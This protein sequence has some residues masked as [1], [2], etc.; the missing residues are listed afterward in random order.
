MVDGGYGHGVITH[1]HPT[2][3]IAS[4]GILLLQREIPEDINE[5][6]AKVR[7]HIAAYALHLHTCIDMIYTQTLSVHT[8]VL[9]YDKH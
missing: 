8:V 9:H 2:Q 7:T 3:L 6:V 1:M 4:A 5:L